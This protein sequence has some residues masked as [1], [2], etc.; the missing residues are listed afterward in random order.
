MS[1]SRGGEEP[2]QADSNTAPL[3]VIEGVGGK[4][5]SLADYRGKVVILEFFAT[6]CEPCRISAPELQSIYAR[7]KDRGVAVIA[8][9]ADEGTDARAR[10]RS[11]MKEYRL[12]YDAATDSG[13]VMKQYGAFTLPTTVIIDREG[14]IRNKHLGIS[15]DY[16]KRL[17]SEID[18]L[19]KQQEK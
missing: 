16:A 19:L 2:K 5:V 12:T 18:Q 11:F 9:A 4:K 17:A 8:V 15:G 14:T 10:V 3:F 1:C 7:Y 13:Q 6:W